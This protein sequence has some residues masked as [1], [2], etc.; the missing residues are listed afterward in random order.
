MGKGKV[1][2]GEFD[3]PVKEEDT[4]EKG[5]AMGGGGCVGG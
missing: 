3:K 2:E 4:E 1:I 5:G